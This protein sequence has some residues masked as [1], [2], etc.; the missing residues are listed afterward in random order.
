[1]KRATAGT[2]LNEHYAGDGDIVYQQAV[3]RLRGH[4]VEAARLALSLG[5]IEAMEQDQEPGGTGRAAVES[6]EEWR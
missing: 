1:M 5:P 6:E 4:R 2:A 3:T